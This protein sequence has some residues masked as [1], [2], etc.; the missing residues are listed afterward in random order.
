MVESIRAVQRNRGPHGITLLA[1][2][3]AGGPAAIDVARYLERLGDADLRYTNLPLTDADQSAIAGEYAFGSAPADRFRVASNSRGD[4][5]IARAGMIERS[6]FH[7]G[8]LVFNPAG[9]EAVKI[10]FD[11]EDGRARR[12]VLEDGAGIVNAIRA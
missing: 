5:T 2:A 4:F 8:G 12:L 1:H 9:A 10:R 11:V 3:R 6:L 7:Q